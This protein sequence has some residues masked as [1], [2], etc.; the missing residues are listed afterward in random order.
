MSRST[1]ILCR[2][3]ALGLGTAGG[4]MGV[5]APPGPSVEVLLRVDA[6][7]GFT[8][9]VTQWEIVPS[10][11]VYADGGVIF[12]TPGAT[13]NSLRFVHLDANALER[14]KATIRDAGVVT[15]TAPDYGYPGV[16]DMA[17]TTVSVDLDG[18]RVRHVAYALGDSFDHAAPL[19]AAQM[20]ARALW[21]RGA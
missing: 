21:R 20:T 8:D 2:A 13:G 3:V 15:A 17:T 6:R 16:T 4:A 5:P 19:S 7:G 1:R 11:N 18:V 14:V 10:L 12:H 9:T